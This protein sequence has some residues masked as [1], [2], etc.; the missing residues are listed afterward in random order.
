[1]ET[2]NSL[3]NIRIIDSAVYNTALHMCYRPGMKRSL[4]TAAPGV[5]CLVLSCCMGNPVSITPYPHTIAPDE[6]YY[7]VVQEPRFDFEL[8]DGSSALSCAVEALRQEATRRG[9][10]EGTVGGAPAMELSLAMLRGGPDLPAD[11]ARFQKGTRGSQFPEAD[12]YGGEYKK[13]SL[14]LIMRS[15][16]GMS[17]GV[18]TRTFPFSSKMGTCASFK[19]QTGE[20]LAGMT[21]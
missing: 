14:R 4:K 11:E 2:S 9:W 1:M 3:K 20:L 8:E 10:H 19:L 5:L 7:L 13:A 6:A 12:P 21:R 16:D 17:E 15:P 18:A